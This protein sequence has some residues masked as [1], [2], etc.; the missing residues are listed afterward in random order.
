MAKQLFQK[1]RAKTGG[2]KKG[3]VT[4]KIRVAQVKEIL[5]A[6]GVHPVAELLRLLP[7]LSSSQ[8]VKVHLELL[9]YIEAK[10]KASEPAPQSSDDEED[11]PQI[12]VS[13]EEL[14]ALAKE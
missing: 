2:R 12:V 7:T 11:L 10:P 3:S 4:K 9:A 5:C 13:P 1:G 8:Q 6:A 14:R